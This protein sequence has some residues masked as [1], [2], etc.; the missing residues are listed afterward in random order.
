MRP[1][2]GTHR[3]PAAAKP[4]KHA[5]PVGREIS[6][7]STTQNNFI[8]S[9]NFT[10]LQTVECPLRHAMSPWCMQ[11][12]AS[13]ATKPQKRSLKKNRWRKSGTIACF[14]ERLHALAERRLPSKYRPQA[15]QKTIRRHAPQR[16]QNGD[17]G[18][19]QKHGDGKRGAEVQPR[20]HNN[21]K[22]LAGIAKNGVSL[23][24][25]RIT[26]IKRR[27]N[28]A[29]A[30]GGS[31]RCGVHG[32]HQERDENGRDGDNNLPSNFAVLA[33][34]FRAEVCGAFEKT[35]DAENSR[36]QKRD[37][38]DDEGATLA[39]RPVACKGEAVRRCVCDRYDVRPDDTIAI[40]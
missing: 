13:R 16:N 8:S 38:H 28:V 37:K 31:Q 35:A 32:A 9:P 23:L 12:C 15:L 26:S 11:T 24:A 20:L 14:D 4:A 5:K 2:Q 29:V 30:S 33:A 19:Q 22:F 39:N 25:L 27:G 7:M 10:S 17:R 21:P 3:C 1:I 40:I 34:D 18:R 6:N 36:S